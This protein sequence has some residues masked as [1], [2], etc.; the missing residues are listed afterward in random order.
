MSH[1]SFVSGFGAS[2]SQPLLAKRP[3]QIVGSG[4]KTSSSPGRRARGCAASG[5]RAA[6]VGSGAGWA[7]RLPRSAGAA[8]AGAGGSARLNGVAW[9]PLR[10][11]AADE[12]VVDG[13][14]PERVG[15]CERLAVGVAGPSIPW[16]AEGAR[17]VVLD[18]VERL[19]CAAGS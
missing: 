3:S 16:A 7:R 4:R 6:A 8:R 17:P 5:G 19:P 13:L 12:T 9:P 2:W 15:V 18:D 10:R 1:V 11:R 14:F